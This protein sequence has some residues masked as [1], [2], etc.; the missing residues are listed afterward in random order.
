SFLERYSAIRP[1]VEK[2]FSS[3]KRTI[4]HWLRSRKKMMQRK[5]TYSYVIA[6]NLV[7]AVKNPLRLI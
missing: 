3:L 7:K 5:E 6:Y 4:A 1:K 2:T